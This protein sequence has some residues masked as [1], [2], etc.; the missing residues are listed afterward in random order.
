VRV[1]VRAAELLPTRLIAAFKEKVDAVGRLDYQKAPIQ[2]R[3]DSLAEHGRLR[4]CEKEPETIAWI[5]Q[6]VRPGDV[7]YDIGANVGAYAFVID[8]FTGGRAKVYA[9]EA[10]FA[11]FAQLSR[12]VFL[13]QCAG[14]VVPLHV[15]LGETTGVIG[16][17]YRSLSPGTSLHTLGPAID[18]REQPFEPVFVQPILSFRLDDLI[19][20]FRLEPPNAIK[21]DVDGVELGILRGASRTLAHPALRTLIVEVEADL[22]SSEAIVTLLS[23]AGFRCEARYRHEGQIGTANYVFLRERAAVSAIAS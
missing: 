22:P 7:V 12:N 8:R 13:N 6:Q 11:T 23:A 3:L 18:H 9:L 16:F 2:L 14:R 21:L 4:S 15:A 17:N 20:T 5:E 19:E 1:A 10:A